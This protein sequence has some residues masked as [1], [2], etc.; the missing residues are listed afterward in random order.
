RRPGRRCGAARRPLPRRRPASSGSS[1]TTGSETR[2][3]QCGGQDR[4][5]VEGQHA[6]GDLL[7]EL[8]TLSG[9]HEYVAGPAL[10]NRQA[11]RGTPV[12]L[13]DDPGRSAVDAGHHRV[14]DRLRV[15]AARV[16]IGE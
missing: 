8:V 2:V 1:V 16:V 4:A 13:D 10:G 11:D 9:D 15:L 3:M 6:A 12:R 5:V 14:E 7:T